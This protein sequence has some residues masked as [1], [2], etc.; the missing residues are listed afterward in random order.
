MVKFVFDADGV[1]KLAKSGVLDSVSVFAAC[2]L[3]T[4]VYEEVLKGKENMYEDAFIVEGLVAKG[5]IKVVTIRKAE[6]M[7]GLG[8]GE[9]SALLLYEKLGADAVISDD[10]KFLS[11][12]EEKEVPF[13]IPTDLIVLLS[14]KGRISKAKARE[15]LDS[16][17]PFVRE[18]NYRLAKEAIGGE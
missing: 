9:Q 3:S 13:I 16:L 11:F 4:Q 7:A 17:R 5:K 8:G 2:H 10:R 6:V 1:I 15:A 12:L 18:E 14:A